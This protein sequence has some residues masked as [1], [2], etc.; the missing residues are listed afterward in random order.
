MF[1]SK[2]DKKTEKQSKNKSSCCGKMKSE[3]E[4]KDV[5]KTPQKV[6]KK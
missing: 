2:Q 6:L 5:I 3:I 1:K 4:N